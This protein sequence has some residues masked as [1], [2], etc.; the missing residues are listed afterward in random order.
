MTT[1]LDGVVR[2]AK[3]PSQVKLRNLRAA[4]FIKIR[5]PLHVV[6]EE[7]QGLIGGLKMPFLELHRKFF[8]GLAEA[9][10]VK[11]YTTVHRVIPSSNK[12]A[13]LRGLFHKAFNPN[14]TQPLHT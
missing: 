13:G 3:T 7:I 12:S 5:S 2:G 4:L 9:C 14:K 6:K 1:K 8:S 11:W 10:S